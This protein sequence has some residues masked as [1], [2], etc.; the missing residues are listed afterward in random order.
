[1]SEFFIGIIVVPL[2]GNV[3]EHTVAVQTAWKNKMELSLAV[4]LGSSLQIALFVAPLLVFISLAMGHPLT[5]VFNQFEIIALVGAAIIGNMVANDGESNWM[6]GAQL[7][8]VYAIL[9]MAFLFLGA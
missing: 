4:S 5:L 7:L 9:A 1:V 2:V 8:T 3:A 6:E